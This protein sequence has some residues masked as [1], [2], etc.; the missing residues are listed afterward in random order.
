M[1]GTKSFSTRKQRRKDPSERALSGWGPASSQTRNRKGEKN[2]KGSAGNH[3]WAAL[4]SRFTAENRS[5]CAALIPSDFDTAP[6]KSVFSETSA[7]PP[8]FVFNIQKGISPQRIRTISRS[9]VSR[10]RRIHGLKG[11]RR[12][13]LDSPK[14]CID[15]PCT[16][17]Y[18]AMRCL[19]E[20]LT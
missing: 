16:W 7:P 10:F 2:W 12:Y 5:G 17:K 18:S 11:L 13:V 19:S 9:P 20:R 1:D 8:E 14:S 6:A 4:N 15:G 3:I